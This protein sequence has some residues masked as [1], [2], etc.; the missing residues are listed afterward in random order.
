MSEIIDSSC[1]KVGVDRYW[2]IDKIIN[3]CQDNI[4]DLQKNLTTAVK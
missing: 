1:G 3:F 4:I 2:A